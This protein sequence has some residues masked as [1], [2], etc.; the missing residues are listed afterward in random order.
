MSLEDD[1][2]FEPVELRYSLEA[3]K[4]EAYSQAKNELLE[5]MPKAK[6]SG[7]DSGQLARLASIQLMLENKKIEPNSA[8]IEARDILS[9][10]N[11]NENLTRAS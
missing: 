7:A 11:I 2:K 5:L 1:T 10:L 9:D 4:E 6:K 3:S 8:V